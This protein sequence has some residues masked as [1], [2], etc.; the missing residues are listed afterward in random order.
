M[1]SNQ[2]ILG[3]NEN[4]IA[5]SST[6]K[7]SANSQQ[8][9]SGSVAKW[10]GCLPLNGEIVGSSLNG[11]KT[12]CL[13]HMTPVEDSSRKRTREWFKIYIFQSFMTMIFKKTRWLYYMLRDFVT[14]VYIVN[15]TK[16]KEKKN[17]KKNKKQK[18]KHT[19]T[20]SEQEYFYVL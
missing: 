8:L 15:F 6:I 9:K 4:C 16:L 19:H 20:N 3:G 5:R 10:L 17:N 2:E 13:P 18:Q 7:L 1:S 14:L 12:I 11:D